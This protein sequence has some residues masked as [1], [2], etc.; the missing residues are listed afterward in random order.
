MVVAASFCGDVFFQSVDKSLSNVGRIK[1]IKSEK[2]KL[3]TNTFYIKVY[4]RMVSSN[5][6]NLKLGEN[7]QTPQ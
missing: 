2:T 3:A 5:E 6:E 7:L 1:T 4:N